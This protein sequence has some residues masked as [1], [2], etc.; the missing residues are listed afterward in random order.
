MKA[1]PV[2]LLLSY[3]SLFMDVPAN[4]SRHEFVY[5]IESENSWKLYFTEIVKLALQG[6]HKI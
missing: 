2:I 6:I 5:L 4:F 1:V 3:V